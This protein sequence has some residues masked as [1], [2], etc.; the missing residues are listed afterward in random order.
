[1]SDKKPRSLSFKVT[2]FLL[3]MI[4]PLNFLA[5]Y[6]TRTAYNNAVSNTSDMVADTLNSHMELLKNRI[7]NTDSFL[8][9]LPRNNSDCIALFNQSFDEE[10]QYTFTKYQLHLYLRDTVETSNM[11]DQFIIYLKKQ[12][13]FMNIPYSSVQRKTLP[14]DAFMPF[15]ENYSDIYTRWFLTH[16]DGAPYLMR[17]FY[18]PSAQ[19]YYGAGINLSPTLQQLGQA[20][21]FDSLELSFTDAPMTA[22]KG[23]FLC[24][25][26]L[27]NI[28]LYLNAA[29]R[30]QD[31]T[32]SLGF[33]QK[34]ILVVF[35][36]YI[37]LTPAL[38]LMF[39][40][41]VEHPLTG[42]NRAHKELQEG[43]ET[44]RITTPARS[45]EFYDAYDS[46]NTMA[47]TLQTLRLE[48]INK[49]LANQKLQLEYLQLQI[50]PHFLLNTF[51]LIYTMIKN[52]QEEPAQ[53]L[54]LYLSD[55]FRHMFRKD[56]ELELFSKE[57]DLIQKYMNISKIYY[58]DAFTVSY[59]LDPVISQ[60]RIPP[61][62][63]HS[64]FENIIQHALVPG[65]VIHIVF[66]GE[67]D[68]G[69][70][71]FHISDDGSG[72]SAQTVDAING[73]ADAP[74]ANGQNV[75]IRNS[76]KRL[77]YYFGPDARVVV[78]SEIH[79]GT[80]FTISIPYNLEEEENEA[81]TCE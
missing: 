11:A 75:G 54:I 6:T 31:I 56:H 50:R 58:P 5:L 46:F 59:Q 55:Y 20:I 29:I 49:E 26:V 52:H 18:D 44:Y 70:V 30:Q 48:N 72:I 57:F 13:D 3:I 2:L 14:Q 77:R 67:Y 17:I 62:L 32:G 81:F 24:N 53:E 25:A 74:A 34:G 47:A 43:N 27:D 21:S 39:K 65:Q 4:L 71:T 41:H 45:A 64:F 16:V 8:Y 19:V 1:M 60:M 10:W 66:Y 69:T 33:W 61:L 22:A 73:L 80:T 78:E 12:D 37:L 76:I 51:N 40:R 36:I 28:H 23:T 15:I 79:G 35:I 7:H 68:A 9:T 38:L 63:L 42:L